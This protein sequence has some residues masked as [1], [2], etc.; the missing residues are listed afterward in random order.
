MVTSV[1]SEDELNALKQAYFD[2]EITD[3][4]QLEELPARECETEE[5]TQACLLND[6][7]FLVETNGDIVNALEQIYDKSGDD[8]ESEDDGEE[9]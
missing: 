5:E 4:V 8:D 1:V 9:N 7:F 6:L 2:L 3:T